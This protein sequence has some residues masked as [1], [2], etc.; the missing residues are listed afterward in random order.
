MRPVF[1]RPCRAILIFVESFPLSA[2]IQ[3]AFAI[4]FLL[5]IAGVV[6]VVATG[7]FRSSAD[8]GVHPRSPVDVE[9]THVVIRRRQLHADKRPSRQPALKDTDCTSFGDRIDG[10]SK[11]RRLRGSISHRPR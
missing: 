1:C 3:V 6:V 2:K 8:R 9:A 11:G 7:Q 10:K 5:T 4:A